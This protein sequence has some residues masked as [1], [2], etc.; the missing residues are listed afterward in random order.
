MK[1]SLDF[2]NMVNR[3]NNILQLIM[4]TVLI[5]I[6]MTA[7]SPDK[8]LRYY[9]FESITYLFPELGL[10]SIA[11]MIAM[12]T[13]GIDLSVV[14]IANLSGIL[15]GVLFHY[16]T[17]DLGME[18]SVPMVMLGVCLSLGVGLV[19]GAINGFLITKLNII[20]ILATL[21]TGQVFIGLC[22]VLTGGPAIVGFPDAWAFLGNGKLFGIAVPFLL[23]LLVAGMVAF[24]LTR[25]TLGVNLMLIG[26]NPR[27]AVFAGLKKSRMILYSYMLSGVLASMAG[28][29]LSG[30][31]NAAKSDY[32]TSYLL[33][34][35]LISVLGGTNPAGGKGTVAGVSI[36]V[37]ALMLLSSGFQILRFSNHL[38]DFIWGAFLLLVI[39]INAWKNRAR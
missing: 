5:F 11:M 28:I 22:L 36:A 2:R 20:P 39:A 9:N 12:L 35:V 1:F 13:G 23:F 17:R 15:S 21:G 30:R 7:L 14:G 4:M 31:T 18:Q 26:S 16:L 32:G 10:L 6:I 38:I 34:A 24:L 3:D 29:I 37:V 25:T 19:A 33:Q 8:F 27:A